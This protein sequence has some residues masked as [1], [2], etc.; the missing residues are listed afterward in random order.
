MAPILSWVAFAAAVVSANTID[1]RA[2]ST[3]PLASCPGYKASNVKTTSSSLTA[4]LELAGHACN[5]YGTDL[6]DLTLSVVYETGESNSLIELGNWL[7]NNYRR[8]HPRQD[9]RCSQQRL[10]GPCF[11]LSSSSCLLRNQLQASEHPVSLH[12]ISV[13]V[14]N[15][16]S[17]Y[18]R[19]SIRYFSSKHRFRIPIPQTP[20]FAPKP[21]QPVRVG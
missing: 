1:L 11:R 17:Q 10:P 19:G 8:P 18:W 3:D 2:P 12:R 6:T 14:F 4:D 7:T 16:S 21:S 20:D 5:V 13:L 15:H 9:P